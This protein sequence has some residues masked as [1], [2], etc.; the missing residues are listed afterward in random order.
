MDTQRQLDAIVDRFEAA[1]ES[2][3]VP[4]IPEFLPEAASATPEMVR[5]LICIDLE[6]RWRRP[7]QPDHAADNDAGLP[8]FP[9][10]EQYLAALCSDGRSEVSRP[11]SVE[12][13]TPQLIAEEYRV[14]RRWGDQPGIEEYLNGFPQLAEPLRPLLESTGQEIKRKNALDE[15]VVGDDPYFWR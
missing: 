13:L 9:R 5:E 14:R 8:A 2:G 3:A 6:R 12:V 15:T 4:A 1:W 7:E 10:L 11:A